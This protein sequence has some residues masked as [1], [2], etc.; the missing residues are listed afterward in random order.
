MEA[1]AEANGPERNKPETWKGQGLLLVVDDEELVRSLCRRMLEHIGFE[2]VTAGDG[3]EALEV[4]KK[5]GSRIR[6]VLLDLTM[7]YMDG[8][9]T[10]TELRRLDPEVRVI[11]CSGYNEQALVNQFF[12]KGL[13]GFIQKPYQ[14]NELT[15]KLKS[16][17]RE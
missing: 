12:E 14:L 9:E 6:C 4:F 15:L 16:V 17:L 2:V 10:F 13:S 5:H 7:P 1:T 3:R 8:R 11:M